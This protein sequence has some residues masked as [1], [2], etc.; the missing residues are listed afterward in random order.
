MR[1]QS[2]GNF[3]IVTSSKQF[4]LPI[5][6]LETLVEQVAFVLYLAACQRQPLQALSG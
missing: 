2:S 3:R 5:R 4:L 1:Q 6:C